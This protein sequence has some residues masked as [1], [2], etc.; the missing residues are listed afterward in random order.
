MKTKIN[1]HRLV[2]LYPTLW[3]LFEQKIVFWFL[4][5]SRYWL[6]MNNF[7]TLFIFF[8]VFQSISIANLWSI[9]LSKAHL[10]LLILINA[11]ILIFH[12]TLLSVVCMWFQ[13][14]GFRSEWWTR[15]SFF[16]ELKGLRICIYYFSI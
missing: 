3:D 9:S 2:L 16:S 11:F 8:L 10:L 12:E 5:T 15:I 14:S 13:V 7:I 4:H 1:K 6:F